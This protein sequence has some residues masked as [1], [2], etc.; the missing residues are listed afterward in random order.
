LLFYSKSVPAK[1]ETDMIT[2]LQQGCCHHHNGW[3]TTKKFLPTTAG[4]GGTNRSVV[5]NVVESVHSLKG[6]MS[7][8]V[9]PE[10]VVSFIRNC[11]AERYVNIG[12]IAIYPSRLSCSRI[13][14]RVVSQIGNNV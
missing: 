8:Q 10:H 1:N 3:H 12:Y 6:G 5:A 7:V 9:I 13:W 11:R 14:R 2:L 4:L